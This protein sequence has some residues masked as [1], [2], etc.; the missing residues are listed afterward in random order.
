MPNCWKR[1]SYRQFLPPAQSI[2]ATDWIKYYKIRK[3]NVLS[4]FGPTSCSALS[5]MLISVATTWNSS[6]LFKQSREF[7][8]RLEFKYKKCKLLSWLKYL[9]VITD[10]HIYFFKSVFPSGC[11][12][13]CVTTEMSQPLPRMTSARSSLSILLVWKSRYRCPEEGLYPED[14]QL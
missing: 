13:L 3:S 11:T 14:I 9:K 10:P 12:S 5:Q 7:K 6:S 1:A 4:R 8:I 2:S